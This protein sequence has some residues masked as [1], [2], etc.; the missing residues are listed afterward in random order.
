MYVY[1]MY[2]KKLLSKHV[3]ESS[4]FFFDGKKIRTVMINIAKRA[5]WHDQ[6]HEERRAE[7]ENQD[8]YT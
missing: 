3:E 2:S 5:V 7:G 8:I 4:E 6:K 1:Y